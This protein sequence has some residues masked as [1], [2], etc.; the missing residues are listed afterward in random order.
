MNRREKNLIRSKRF[1]PAAMNK[2]VKW[3]LKLCL[4]VLA[5]YLLSKKIE[6]NVVKQ[7]IEDANYLLLIVALLLYILSKIVSAF[8]LN[9]LQ[10]QIGVRLSERENTTLYFIG[11]FYNLFLPGGIGGD[12]YKGVWIKRRFQVGTKEVVSALFLDRFFGLCALF[13]LL[14]TG[15][16]FTDLFANTPTTYYW[17]VT[18]LFVL[19]LPVTYIVVRLFFS[20]F[21]RV[22][23]PVVGMS[24]LVQAIQIVEALVIIFAIGLSGKIMNYLVLFLASSV[25]AVL[26]ISV[27]GVG[28]RELTFVYGNEYLSIEKNQAVAFSLI[29]FLITAISSLSGSFL[30]MR[31][32]NKD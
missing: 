10:R 18:I 4:T 7:I 26:P 14:F 2:W 21:L 30:R 1:I 25:A 3:L 29:F 15:L 24:L 8:R 19:V 11:M 23:W 6:W 22:F 5:L 13:L 16:Y 20:Q 27:G 28:V 17:I 31:D 9:C 12:G 32:S